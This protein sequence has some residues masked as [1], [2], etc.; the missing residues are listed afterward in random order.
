MSTVVESG[1]SRPTDVRTASRVLAAVLI[2][3]GP[4]AVAVLRFILPYQAADSPTDAVDLV[5]QHQAAQSAVVW[6]GFLACLTLVPGVWFAGRVV[7]RAAPRLASVATVLLVAGYISLSWLTVGDALLLFGVRHHLPEDV[8]VSVMEAV[9]PAAT[10]AA[11]IFVL[12]HVLG[13]ILL[14]I[15]MLRG[16]VVAG[17]AATATIVAQPLHFVAAVVVGSP[18]L[19]LIGWGLNA[20]G[21]AALSVVVWHLPND[22]WGPAPRTER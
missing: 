4:A 5:A 3:I 1:V 7:G 2:P 10:V 20:V 15:G 16:H 21:F 9:H 22:E 19:D 17:W 13:T 14:G 8:L 18:T 12:G 6:I 11:G